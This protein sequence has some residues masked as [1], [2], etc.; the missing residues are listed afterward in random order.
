MLH[1]G[2]RYAEQ[3]ARTI[4]TVKDKGFQI[5]SEYN[6]HQ[7]TQ[8]KITV[9]RP[10]C[11]HT[12]DV[13]PGNIIVRDVKCPIC[14]NEAKAKRLQESHREQLE[15]W[16][17]TAPDWKLY[18]STVTSLTRYTYLEHKAIINPNNFPTGRAGTVGA[19]HLDHIVSVRYGFTHSIDPELISH[20]TNLQMLPW[21]ENIAKRDYVTLVPEILKEYVA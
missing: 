11:N 9:F 15:Q 18:R 19:Y 1:I 21:E 14:N 17:K 8:K 12:F 5:L 4:Q 2:M 7:S 10:S 3:R 6:G 20:Y 13:A 16:R